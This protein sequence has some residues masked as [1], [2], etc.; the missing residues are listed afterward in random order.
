M[1]EGCALATGPPRVNETPN[2]E[3]EAAT[4]QNIEIEVGSK[5]FCAS[6]TII[7]SPYV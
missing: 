6:L 4:P 2:K 1:G 5:G 3:N 7:R